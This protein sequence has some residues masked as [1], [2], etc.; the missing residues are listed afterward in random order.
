MQPHEAELC[1]S[2]LAM[3]WAVKGEIR[4]YLDHNRVISVAITK[5]QYLAQQSTYWQERK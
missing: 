2:I 1:N 5:V 4:Q 3:H